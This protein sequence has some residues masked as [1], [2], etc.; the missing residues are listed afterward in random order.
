MNSGLCLNEIALVAEVLAQL[1]D[2][3]DPA[4]DQALQ[5][6][7]GRDPQVEVAVERVVV[8]HERPGEC[9]AVDRLEDGRLD[10]DEAL[11]VE[12]AAGLGDH[13]G[14]LEEALAHLGV[15]DQVLLAVAVA[16]L[17]V[18]EPRP[19]VGRRA[20]ALGEERPV[21]DPQRQLALAA[22]ERGALDADDVAEVEAGE[23]CVPVAQ[24]GLARLELDL[25][26]AVDEVEEGDLSHVAVGGDPPGDAVRGLG[27]LAVLQAVVFGA[28]GR[29]LHAAVELV[30]E[31]L[32][33]R[34]RAGARASRGA[35]R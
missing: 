29:D 3:L 30:R 18:L 35:R 8:R 5:V 28:D 9:A 34:S 26:R 22:L 25:A 14:A 20:K 31:R 33:A 27:L 19:L 13:L 6:E 16:K 24:V 7:L 4:D 21:R 32:D 23:R 1:V 12:P 11:G 17:G 15:R 2:A 10:L